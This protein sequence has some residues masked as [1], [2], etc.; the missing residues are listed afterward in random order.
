MKKYSLSLFLFD[1]QKVTD[2]LKLEIKYCE[3]CTKSG[4]IIV[5]KRK[6]R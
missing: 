6:N 3:K 5:K 4:I 2:Y 1:N